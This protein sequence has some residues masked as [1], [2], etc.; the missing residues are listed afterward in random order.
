[1]K[2]KAA[3]ALAVLVLSVAALVSSD[4]APAS[5]TTVVESLN[6]LTMRPAGTR[7]R[8]IN[9]SERACQKTAVTISDHVFA[10]GEGIRS[11]KVSTALG[12]E[13]FVPVAMIE[14]VISSLQRC[15]VA[16]CEAIVHK[17][18][19]CRSECAC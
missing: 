2:M 3:P 6:L 19:V 14:D 16:C 12:H 5:S 9:W 18:L 11:S 4:V 15:Q 7:E 1:M 10:A 8:F 13:E 17:L